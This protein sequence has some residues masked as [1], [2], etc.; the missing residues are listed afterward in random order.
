MVYKIIHIQNRK[1]II[2]CIS[3]NVRKP[4]TFEI[5]VQEYSGSNVGRNTDCTNSG[6]R[7]FSSVPPS[8]YMVVPIFGHGCFLPN[9]FHLVIYQSLPSDGI[10]PEVLTAS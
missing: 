1:R 3:M 4:M 9:P 6:C 5:Y 2:I 10:Q 7:R 8:K